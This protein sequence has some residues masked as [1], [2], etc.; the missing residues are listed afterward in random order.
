MKPTRVWMHSDSQ[1][2]LDVQKIEIGRRQQTVSENP[3]A[4]E[5]FADGLVIEFD[6]AVVAQD[7]TFYFKNSHSK[8]RH[9]AIELEADIIDIPA[10]DL[11]H[12]AT[13]GGR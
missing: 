9:V 10:I 3:L 2:D 5:A 8:D 11:D 12:R 13:D 1:A 7:M 6:E 4:V